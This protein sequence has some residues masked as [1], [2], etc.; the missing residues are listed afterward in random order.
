M[1]TFTPIDHGRRVADLTARLASGDLGCDVLLF[2]DLTDVRWLTG[3]TGSNGWAVLRGDELTFGTDGRYDDRARVET[4]DAGAEVIALQRAPDLRQALVGLLRGGTVGLDARSVN[5]AVWSQLVAEVDLL[6]I[7]S[8]IAVAR[9]VKDASEIERMAAAA[10]AADAALNEV[11]PVLRAT[12]DTPVK[13][14]DIRNELEYRMRLHGADDRSYNTIVATGPDNAARPHHEV[15]HRT[16][17]TGDTVVI[18][19]GGLVD[20]YHSDM[21]RSYVIGDPTAQQREMYELVQQ[22]QTAGLAALADGVTAQSV[23]AACRD[24]FVDAGLGDWFIHGTGHGVGLQIHESP[25]HS[26]VSSEM[27]RGG[28]VV[29]VE[30]GLYRGGFGGIRIEDL[31][32]VTADGHRCLTHHPKRPFA[33]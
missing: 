24:V 2:T 15:G 8:P 27:I 13:E 9:Q 33:S 1:Q 20:G 26:Q 32:V 6:A 3:F 21:T 31:V 16:I 5:H 25:F 18:D 23:D 12:T 17:V 4:A 19:V 10:S 7:E 11:E 22:S 28:N 30:P 29:T 14:A